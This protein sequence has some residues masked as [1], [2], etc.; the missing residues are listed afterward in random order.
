MQTQ[1][2]ELK[3]VLSEEK[4]IAVRAYASVY[5]DLDESGV[6]KPNYA[7]PVHSIYLDSPENTTFWQWVNSDRNRFKL[8]MRYYD[9]SPN[10]PVFLEI[11]RRVSG[12]ILKQRCAVK[13]SAGEFILSGLIPPSE[14]IVSDSPKQRVALERFV[15]MVTEMRAQPK[16]LVSYSREAYV[17]PE[18]DGVRVTLDRQIRISPRTV[19]DYSL[20]MPEYVQPFGNNVVLELKF[21]NRFPIWFSQMARELGLARSA[22]A[23]YC[24]GMSALKRPELGYWGSR[25]QHVFA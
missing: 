5:L 11:K 8:R 12:C 14:L 13:K 24:E 22:A 16:A 20:E 15:Q 4:A 6:G 3:Y 10:T 1:R 23:K 25:A 7:Y 2:F 21:N 17:D 18:N 9:D 19:L